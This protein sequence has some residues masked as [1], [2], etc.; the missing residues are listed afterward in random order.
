MLL[1]YEQNWVEFA[2]RKLIEFHLVEVYMDFFDLAVNIYFYF[3]SFLVLSWQ[4]WLDWSRV[5]CTLS[6]YLDY[7][8]CIWIFSK[9]HNEWSKCD[10]IPRTGLHVTHILLVFVSIS[11]EWIT[12]SWWCICA[13]CFTLNAFLSFEYV[14]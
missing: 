10:L 11:I 3:S 8:E 5:L 4:I 9:V 1:E 7:M 2:A 14:R 13:A 6:A 12:A